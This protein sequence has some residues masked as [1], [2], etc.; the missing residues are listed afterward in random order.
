KKNAKMPKD[1][2]PDSLTLE[3]VQ[4]LIADAPAR[5]K[6]GRRSSAKRATKK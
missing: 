5:K 6:G 4:Q 3:E 1:R 2:T